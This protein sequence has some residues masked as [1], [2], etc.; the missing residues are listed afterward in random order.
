ME[1]ANGMSMSEVTGGW[2]RLDGDTAVVF[3]RR[4]A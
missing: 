3:S 2:K 1:S 4:S